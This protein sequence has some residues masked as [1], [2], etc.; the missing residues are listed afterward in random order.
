MSTK[1]DHLMT[2]MTV[3]TSHGSVTLRQILDNLKVLSVETHAVKVSYLV[4]RSNKDM[5][6]PAPYQA[7]ESIDGQKFHCCSYST[8]D[9]D[10]LVINDAKILNVYRA[11]DEE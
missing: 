9:E 4:T 5:P 2:V 11:Y 7:G 3:M 8:V 1:N 6:W 10:E